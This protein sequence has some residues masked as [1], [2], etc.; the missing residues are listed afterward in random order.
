MEVRV[1]MTLVA[2]PGLGIPTAFTF[3][4]ADALDDLGGPAARFRANVAAIG[5]LAA[6]ERDGAPGL[7]LSDLGPW[8][9]DFMGAFNPMR[10]DFDGVGG[11]NIADLAIWARAYFAGGSTLSIGTL[12]P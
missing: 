8:V 5:L 6:V 7:T 9:A 11:V 3:P 10:A 4:T 1:V 2:E 12:C